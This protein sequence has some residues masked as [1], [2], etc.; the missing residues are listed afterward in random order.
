MVGVLTCAFGI[1]W[2]GEGVGIKWPG[3]DWSVLVLADGILA[4][5]LIVARLKK[6]NRVS[7]PPAKAAFTG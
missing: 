7:D 2:M 1:F 6:S 5:A 4:V 3:E